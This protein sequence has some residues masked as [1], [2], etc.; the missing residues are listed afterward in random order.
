MT[1]RKAGGREGDRPRSRSSTE[2]ESGPLELFGHREAREMIR[3]ELE[4]GTLPRVLL[5]TGPRGI[6]KEA[7]GF[8]VARLLLCEGPE[9]RPCG[10]C[11][12]CG[13][14]AA[15]QHPDVHWFFPVPAESTFGE[16]DWARL[17][18]RIRKDP[19]DPD[20]ARFSQPASFRMHQAATIRRLAATKSFQGGEQIFVLGNYEQN[21]SDQVHNALLKLFEE[22]PPR[23]TF[24]LTTSRLQGLPAT[25]LSRC[26]PV[27]LRPLPE[28]E[29]RAFASAVANRLNKDPDPEEERQLLARAEG[30][31]GR[32]L[33]LLHADDDAT[34]EAALLLRAAVEGGP[35]ASYAWAL[36][37]STRGS[38]EDH[39]RRLD[40]LALLWRDLLRVGAGAGET[41][42]R[43]DLLDLYR[44]ASERLD[45]E[46]GAAAALEL[47]RA[48]ERVQA[49]VYVPLVF[50]KLFHALASSFEARASRAPAAYS[51]P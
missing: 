32:V 11:P 27:R 37:N 5:V 14:I 48:R 44:E 51:S 41:L 23:T 47:E 50:W 12:S 3:A 13:K 29:M 15:L 34:D 42:A 31:P 16:S 7:F 10:H 38:R 20:H 24:V 36:T 9:P 19:L 46:R 21:P 2:K 39:D 8:W 35:V 45:P 4:Q 43:P 26:R 6:G 30:R 22:P 28:D 33:E 17:L 1:P 25:I 49:N 18:A 40:G